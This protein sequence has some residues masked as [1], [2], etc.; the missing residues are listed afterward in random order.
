[1]SIINLRFS[2]S[3]EK[4]E[5]EKWHATCIKDAEKLSDAKKYHRR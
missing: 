4:P 1:V 3:F 5:S 2:S